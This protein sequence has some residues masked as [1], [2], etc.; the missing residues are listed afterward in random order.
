M[1]EQHRWVA[2]LMESGFSLDGAMQVIKNKSITL[3]LSGTLYDDESVQTK[4]TCMSK[5]EA[6]IDDERSTEGDW[7]NSDDKVS[8]FMR[9]G[10]KYK[11]TMTC[12]EIE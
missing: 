11:I 5:W 1:E 12:E 10:R 3:T 6:F 4:L 2:E 8:A 7:E 9:L